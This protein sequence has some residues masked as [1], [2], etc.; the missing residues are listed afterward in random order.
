VRTPTLLRSLLLAGVASLAMALASCENSQPAQARAPQQGDVTVTA[1]PDGVQ[2]VT[3]DANDAFRFVPATVRV[4]VGKVRITLKNVGSTP[5]NLAFSTLSD[6]AGK[7]AVPLA[8]GGTEQTTEFTVN[9]PGTYR[10][11]CTI[12]EALNQTGNLIVS[13]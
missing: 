4:H 12:H 1:G 6:K 3:I 2:S 8:R 10:F 9:T 11:V 7:V 13:P 5:H